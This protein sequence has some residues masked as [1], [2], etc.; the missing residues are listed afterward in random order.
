MLWKSW[1]PF[2]WAY[3][4][5][6][7]RVKWCSEVLY[8]TLEFQT[9][10]NYTEKAYIW[11]LNLKSKQSCREVSDARPIN[12]FSFSLLAKCTPSCSSPRPRRPWSTRTRRTTSRGAGF[13]RPN[14]IPNNEKRC[15]INLSGMAIWVHTSLNASWRWCYYVI[16]SAFP[17]ESSAPQILQLSLTAW[18][19]LLSTFYEST[20]LPFD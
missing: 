19:G 17:F 4:S 18:S 1:G 10:S 8:L 6:H 14:V 2:C 16:L 7:T 15:D 20:Q 9:T 3:E 5:L 12:Q 13:R 11:L